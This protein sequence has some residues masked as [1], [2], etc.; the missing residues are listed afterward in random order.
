[1]LGTVKLVTVPPFAIVSVPMPKLPNSERAACSVPAGS[2]VSHRH[3]ASR[4]AKQCDGPANTVQHAAVSDYKSSRA[5]AANHDGGGIGQ[6]P[7]ILDYEH[8]CPGLT[9]GESSGLC[10]RLLDHRQNGVRCQCLRRSYSRE[11]RQSS[12]HSETDW[13]VSVPVQLV[14]ACV[15]TVDAMK[16]PIAASKVDETSS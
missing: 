3:R 1:M 7:A 15:E 2:R 8:S 4:A 5:R 16:S 13:M 11:H 9:D 10:T 14:W 12:C 6:R